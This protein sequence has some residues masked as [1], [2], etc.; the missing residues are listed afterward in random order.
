MAKILRDPKIKKLNNA[1]IKYVSFAEKLNFNHRS[2]NK[3]NGKLLQKP[4]PNSPLTNPNGYK[5]DTKAELE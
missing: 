3:L 5:M 4:K 2:T 1:Q